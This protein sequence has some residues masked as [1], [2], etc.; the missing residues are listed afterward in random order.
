MGIALA[1][2]FNPTLRAVKEQLFQS[3]RP[4]VVDR[5]KFERAFGGRLRRCPMPSARRAR[6]SGIKLR[7]DRTEIRAEIPSRGY[8]ARSCGK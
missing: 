4:W 2:L 3:E 8:E 7:P 5:S 6:G 1:A